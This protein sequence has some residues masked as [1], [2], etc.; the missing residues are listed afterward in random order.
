VGFRS[1]LFLLGLSSAPVITQGGFRT[2]VPGWN[3][4]AVASITQGGFITPLPFLFGGGG[5]VTDEQVRGGRARRRRRIIHLGKRKELD[6]LA[7]ELLPEDISA[8]TK[9]AILEG[10]VDVNGI[11]VIVGEVPTAPVP[12]ISASAPALQLITDQVERKIAELIRIREQQEFD[13]L[14]LKFQEEVRAFEEEFMI[15]LILM[16]EC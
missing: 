3:A 1:P 12:T 16:V 15:F 9:A 13:Q 6:L 8:T 7:E 5:V 2:P 4:G 11:E 14:V 10:K